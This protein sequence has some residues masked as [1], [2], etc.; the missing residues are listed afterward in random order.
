MHAPL[1]SI[2]IVTWNCKH[3]VAQCLESIEQH[4]GIDHEVIVVDNDSADGTPV[5]IERQFPSVC[6]IRSGGNIGFARGNNI[7]IAASRGK[8]LALINPDVVLLEGC[9]QEAL[10]TLSGDCSVGIVGP[11]MVG[12]DGKVHRSGMRR[13]SI[14]N[15]FCDALL[16]HRLLGRRALFGGQMMA[17]F[18]W[19]TRRDVEVLNG[20]LWLVRR[21]AVDRVGGLDERFFMYGEDVDWCRRFTD[22]GWRIVFEPASSAVHYG[23]GSSRQAPLRLYLELERAKRLYWSKYH[24]WPACMVHDAVTWLHH[25]VRAAAFMLKRIRNRDDQ[26]LALKATRHMVCLGLMRASEGAAEHLGTTD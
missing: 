25:G 17:D 20:W 3:F 15:S 14:W 23:G 5:M 6:V 1:L 24:S 2:I 12:P 19:R 7:G 21:A 8:Y 10:N 11:A 16:L 18:D 26:T 13:P 22:A 9:L 4:A